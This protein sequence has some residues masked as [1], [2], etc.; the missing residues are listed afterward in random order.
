M[1]VIIII[2]IIHV[3][4]NIGYTY[5]VKQRRPVRADVEGK[6]V[7]SGDLIPA[8]YISQDIFLS[9][10]LWTVCKDRCPFAAGAYLFCC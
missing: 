4:H 3:A 1:M 7:G 5:I 6:R 10:Q 9:D 8:L 2:I